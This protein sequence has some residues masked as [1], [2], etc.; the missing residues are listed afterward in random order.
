M[1]RFRKVVVIYSCL[2]IMLLC[3]DASGGIF[4]RCRHRACCSPCSQACNDCFKVPGYPPDC[5]NKVCPLAAMIQHPDAGYTTYYAERCLGVYCSWDGNASQTG[6]CSWCPS[7]CTGY[8][9]ADVEFFKE[10]G[11]AEQHVDPKLRTKGSTK[12]VKPKTAKVGPKTTLLNK[13]GANGMLVQVKGK[14]VVVQLWEV[15]YEDRPDLI[16]F[17]GHQVDAAATE[18]EEAEVVGNEKERTMQIKFKDH[19][20]NPQTYSVL[21]FEI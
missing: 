18:T 14:N 10:R 1:N 17:V 4:R 8:R 12:G 3:N 13:N 5:S 20:K 2:A 9:I 15:Q 19:M 6:P 21:L 11:R 16:F 7:S